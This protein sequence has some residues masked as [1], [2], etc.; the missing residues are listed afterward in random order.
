MT[1]RLVAMND[2]SL[3][4]NNLVLALRTRLATSGATPDPIV[5]LNLAVALMR[6]G[7]FADALTELSRVTLAPGPGVSSGTVHYLLGLCHEQL[8]RLSEAEKQWRLAAADPD[9]LLTED[10]PFV[11]EAAESKLAEMRK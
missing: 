1:P 7:N 11:K 10:G 2:Q 9:A 8:G 4:F 5:R 6:L 3:L